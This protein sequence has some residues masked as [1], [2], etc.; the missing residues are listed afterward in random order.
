MKKFSSFLVHSISSFLLALIAISG[1]TIYSP[2]NLAAKVQTQP[3][4]GV[5]I[6]YEKHILPNGLTVILHEDH[7]A[8]IV[9]FNIWYHVGSKDEKAGKTGFAHLFEHLMFNGSEHYN[10]DY[11][12]PLQEVGATDLN[13]TTNEDRT[14]YF[15][16]VPVSSLDL[17]LWLESDRMGFLKGAINQ[18]KLD[19]QRGVVQNELRQYANEPYAVTEELIARA[20]FPAGHPYSWT[21]GGSIE[22]LNRASIEDVHNWFSTYYG[23]N[24]AV[25]VISGDIK[26]AEVLAKVNKYFGQIP[27]SPPVARQSAWVAKRSGQHRQQVQDRVPQARLYKIWNIPQWGTAEAD[28]LDLAS[29]ILGDGKTSRLYKRL[30]YD[31]QLADSVS[32]VVDLR[33]IAGLFY[34]IADAKPGV[35]LSQVEKAIDEELARFLESGP[36]PEE[37]ER[38][39]TG[40]LTSF[41]KGVEKVGG[42]SGKADILARGQVFTGQPDYYQENLRHVREASLENIK[43]T[44]KKWLSDGVYVL[45]VL[46]YPQL[47]TIKSDVNRQK[48][49]EPGTPP[50]A[51][52]PKIEKTTLSNGLKLILA[53]RH[54]I[55]YVEMS[56]I[57]DAG[58]AA[59]QF[60]LPGTASLAMQMLDEGTEKRSSLEIS[61]QLALLGAE[62]QTGSGLDFSYVNLGV[63][64]DKLSPA[65]DIYSDLIL[66]PSFPQADFERIKK[67]QLARIQQEKFS[68]VGLAIR[69]L[70][71]LIYGENHAYGQ[72]LTGSGY[73][74]TVSQIKRDDLVKY[75]QTW[76]KP[77]HSTLIIVGDVTMMDIKPEIEKIFKSWKAGDVPKKNITKVPLKKQPGIYLLDRPDAPQSVVMAGLPAPSSSD[78]E[79]LAIDLMNFIFGGDFV[80]RIN[81]NLRE[82]KHWSYGVFSTLVEARGQRPFLVIAPVQADK[83][84]ETIEEILAEMKGIS[85]NKPITNN[86]YLNAK[87]SRVNQLPSLWETMAGVENSLVELV[88]FSLPDDYFEKYPARINQ[89]KIEDLNRAAKSVLHPESLVWLVVGDRA[90]LEKSLRE[91]GFGP[92]YYLDRDGQPIK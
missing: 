9:A 35:E 53:E 63:L 44:A 5:D 56:L 26:P 16:T 92:I 90:K 60:A 33:E 65:L 88:N 12:K 48:L 82:D 76:F 91:L 7:K 71:G 25:I 50:A 41:I 20:V 68:P 6:P 38:V 52:F 19:E 36:K 27:P 62:L 54:S 69:V 85:G 70:P 13:G 61:E 80:S 10:D 29:S 11:F 64:K 75:H 45:E 58:Y 59:D 73:E 32:V 87:N 4:S 2:L 30:V 46:P 22:D 84:K 15:E 40:Y 67:I 23:P 77:N 3:S 34:I 55:P 89:L 83:T 72:P 24:N 51:K 18:A 42:F 47:S 49:P 8:P 1:L 57:V 81:L 31:D 39:R 66:H 43:E 14:N 28:Y 17:V 79:A 78:P 37:L 86:E 74:A 21:V